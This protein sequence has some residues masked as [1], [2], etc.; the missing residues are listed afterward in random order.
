MTSAL[1]SF[2]GRIRIAAL[3]IPLVALAC[4]AHSQT[5]QESPLQK[6]S[7]PVELDGVIDEDAW[8]RISPLPL[9]MY[10][11][12]YRGEMSEKTVIKVAYDRHH[13]YVAGKMYHE[14]PDDIR[15]NS[16]YRDGYSE[17][18]TFAIVIDPF[19]DNENARWFFTNPAGV[20]FDMA[21]SNDADFSAGNAINDNWNTHWEVETT[22]TEE[23]WFAEMRIPFSSLGLQVAD[24]RAEIG[25]TTYRYISRRVERHIY[26]P[27]PPNWA[28]GM[29]KPSQT[30]DVVLE[31]VESENPLYVT[32]YLLGGV[33][34][35]TRL[36][37]S[38]SSYETGK[39][40][41]REAGFDLKYNLT[42]NFTL[43]ATFNTDFAQVEADNQQVNLTR[44]PLF[45][46]EKRQF[47]Q[48][49]SSTFAFGLGGRDQLFFSRRI[50]LD[51]QGQP[52]RIW[53]GARLTGRTGKWDVGL[54]NMQTDDSETLP[55]ENFG[56][57]RLKRTTFNENS[58]LG[59]ILTSRLS[60]GGHNLAA[61][62][63]GVVRVTESDYA[64]LRYAH[65]FYDGL[66]GDQRW[67]PGDTGFLR[68]NWSKRRN[69]GFYYSASFTRSG[70]NF[71]PG[72]G[73]VTRRDFTSGDLSLSFARLSGEESGLRRWE[74]QGSGNAFYRNPDG[75]MESARLSA[76][77]AMEFVSGAELNL[78]ADWRHEDLRQSISF[79]P[80]TEV[81]AGEYDFLEAGLQFSMPPYRLLRT[82]L[83][84][85]AGSFYDGWRYG[86][87]AGP[88]WNASQHLEMEAEY[89]FNALRFPG[90]DQAYD[91]HI[92]RL[93]TQA[94]LDRRLSARTFVQYSNVAE[95]VAANLR[96]RYN[97]G[98]GRDLW[99]VYNEQLNTDRDPLEPGFPRR[100]QTQAR[101]L[102]LKFTYTFGL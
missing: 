14:D 21:V 38:G 3:A 85:N 101:A 7:G 81:P 31:G 75:S 11:P 94:A 92:L 61:G 77:G 16:L 70:R 51:Q 72:M 73:F 71:N 84:L 96:M 13:I 33:E 39:D 6:L 76:E 64:T 37:R 53:G 88:V 50:G 83:N 17:D 2:I 48:E 74:I 52:I 62:L 98:E 8:E 91:A 100:P 68:V 42:S 22:R 78:T 30:R 99:L 4:S 40:L 28:M 69:E 45:F 35:Q 29:A 65:T 19:N 54:I 59:G 90:R 20:R 66:T 80:R 44:F 97:F 27:I 63:D 25:F 12:V 1:K 34:R 24:G 15:V 36:N 18:D 10:E 9:I 56:V 46:P 32:P 95:L 79:L 26:P 5:T 87:S 57:L 41:S 86:F 60:E 89:S 93:R 47:F 43:D 55:S 58:Y 23:G 49:R 67:D 102:L 82:S